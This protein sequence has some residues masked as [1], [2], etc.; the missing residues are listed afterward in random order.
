MVWMDVMGEGGWGG[1]TIWGSMGEKGGWVKSWGFPGGR[2][3]WG[4]GG[5]LNPY[6]Y[7]TGEVPVLIVNMLTSM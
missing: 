5:I 1:K 4:S 2:G 6:I 7:N 3:I